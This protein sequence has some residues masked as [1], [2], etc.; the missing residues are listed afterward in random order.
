[1][2]VSSLDY[3]G[4]TF[5]PGSW[6]YL[7]NLMTVDSALGR[8]L[9]EL[10]QKC[11][12]AVVLTSDH[13]VAPLVERALEH[14]QESSR[15]FPQELKKEVETALEKELGAGP[16]IEVFNPPFLVLSKKAKKR[17]TKVME[18]LKAVLEAR[19]DVALAAD[20]RTAFQHENSSDDLL[21]AV[22][23]SVGKDAPGDM[24]VVFKRGVVVDV[25]ME[26]GKGTNHGSP[27][28]YD[29]EVP[30]LLWGAGVRQG[31][32]HEARSQ[33]RAAATLSSLLGVG[34]EMAGQVSLE[35]PKPI[36]P[37]EPPKR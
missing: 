26:S 17:R 27:W 11:P 4:H 16:F 33:L 21:R 9:D 2:S 5:G 35:G 3:I 25:A 36:P 29:R 28:D 7:E 6:E 31:E 8:F 12:L 24:Y 20:V 10:E 18:R 37:P 30:L 19:A 15:V 34:D 1:V 23:L 22:A 32:T 14:D 13:G